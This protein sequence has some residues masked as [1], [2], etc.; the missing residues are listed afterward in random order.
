MI[1][2]S[3]LDL[4]ILR[5]GINEKGKFDEND[6]AKSELNKLGVGRILDQLASLKERN[7]ITMN[8][9]GSFSITEDVKK[10][11]WDENTPIEIRILRILEISPQTL[12]KI[13]SLLLIQEDRI[14]KAIEELQKN[15]LV[16][17]STVKKEERIVKMYEILSEGVEYLSRVNLGITQS[18]SELN[19]Q[20]KNLDSLQDTIEEISKL[21]NISEEEK[22]KIIKNLESV[23]KN[24]DSG[25][26]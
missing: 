9:E 19:P 12:Q 4:G 14:H 16:L 2:L 25:L 23:K 18:I 1:K 3:L 21:K 6:I 26:L 8:K 15:H 17:M 5:L 24:L 13:A 11:L 10:A 22:N 20:L 7:L